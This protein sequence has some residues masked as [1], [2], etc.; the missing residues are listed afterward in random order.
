MNKL[1]W[2]VNRNSYIFIQENPF[3]NVIWKIAVILSWSQCVKSA[4]V[5]ERVVLW[6]RDAYMCVSIY[7]S[8][9]NWERGD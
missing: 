6:L 4:L 7:V 9:V 5:Q 2:N 1:Q 3:E 8:V